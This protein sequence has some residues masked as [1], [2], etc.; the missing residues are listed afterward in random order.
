MVNDFVLWKL[1]ELAHFHS[2]ALNGAKKQQNA[3]NLNFSLYLTWSDFGYYLLKMSAEF[4]FTV[5]P[6]S[7][8]RRGSFQDHSCGRGSHQI[9]LVLAVSWTKSDRSC[10]DLVG[11]SSTWCHRCDR[12]TLAKENKKRKKFKRNFFVWSSVVRS[13]FGSLRCLRCISGTSRI[14]LW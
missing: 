13:W 7:G 8:S 3:Q 6:S 5:Q 14:D 9:P 1:W 2:D 10:R 4:C 12:E 11:N